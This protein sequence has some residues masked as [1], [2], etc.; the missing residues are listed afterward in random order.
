MTAARLLFVACLLLLVAGPLFADEEVTRAARQFVAD[1]E[2]RLRKLDITA[3]EAWWEASTTGSKEAFQKK[4]DAQNKIDEA[5]GDRAVFARLEGLEKKRKQ[6]DDPIVARAIRVLYLLYLEKQV[7]AKLLR[8]MVERSN[9]VEEQFNKFRAKVAGKE[10]TDNEVRG[11][12]RNSTDSKRLQV[13]WEASKAV[14]GVVEK[15]LKELVKVRNQAAGKLGFKNYHAL[16]LYLNEQDGK[17]LLA[18]F[19]DLDELTRKPFENAKADLDARLARRYKLK[20]A[21]LMAWHYHDPFFQD[22]P[23]VFDADLDEPFRRADLEKMCRTFYAGIGL[24]IDRVLARSDLYDKKDKSPHAFCTDINRA[25]DVRV[26]ANIRPNHQ[27]AS[28][29]LHELGHAVYSTNNDNIPATLPY[30][31]RWEAHI[32]TTEGVA[33]MF[34]R[35]ANRADFLHKMGLPVKD[36]KAFDRDAATALRYRLLIFSRWCQV[37]LRFEKG[38]YENPE[39]DLNKLWWDLVEKYQ[40]VKRP[41]GRNAPDYA[42]KIHIVVAPVYYHNYM[43]GELFA[44]QVHHA[45]AR[46][47][48]R[49]A[50]P[51]TV[52]YVDNKAVGEFMKKRVFAPGRT[53]DWDELTRGATGERLNAKAFAADFK[54]K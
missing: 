8:Q 16:Q 49:G 36:A 1:H 54:S 43:M 44:S 9:A 48:Y 4:I 34:E 21:D 42:S 38:M 30:P 35:L 31:L 33:M 11:V 51:D 6:I 28:T 17:K 14:G 5:L 15:D 22:T 3:N 40:Q 29:M 18:L 13:V 37:M 32:L 41:A 46:E 47:V 26:L 7:D 53:V 2:K 12:L 23:K 27:W 20:V 39:Q 24:P 19:D 10:L 25:G 45:I 52:I 50:D